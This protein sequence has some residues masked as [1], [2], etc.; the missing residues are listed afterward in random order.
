MATKNVDKSQYES[1]IFVSCQ[2]F[3]EKPS[4]ETQK[5]FKQKTEFI[6]LS[7][8]HIEPKIVNQNENLYYNEI[9]NESSSLEKDIYLELMKKVKQEGQKVVDLMEKL[10][11][12]EKEKSGLFNNLDSQNQ[13][14]EKLNIKLDELEIKLIEKNDIVLKRNLSKD[15]L[16]SELLTEKSQIKEIS[17]Q[18]NYLNE[19][20]KKRLNMYL[21]TSDKVKKLEGK[22]KIFED[23]N[24]MLKKELYDARD[25]LSE[26]EKL[27]CADGDMTKVINELNQ[28]Q[29]SLT[30]NRKKTKGLE[31]EILI[32]RK[33][34]EYLETKFSDE[35]IKVM[36]LKRIMVEK[37]KGISVFETL[38]KSY[39]LF[40][41][42]L[43]A[44]FVY[45]QTSRISN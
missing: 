1:N 16:V 5:K 23:E 27:N 21:E 6:N 18:K 33:T 42:L 13:T 38:T 31:E 25:T 40:G 2:K 43:T 39:V 9:M 29:S 45:F 17:T 19:Q 37:L 34:I 35:K 8:L 36:D 14:I 22:V 30:K 44:V 3:Y 41:Y 7:D 4:P 20:N 15:R 12:C 10:S 11:L 28:A 32:E 24:S 26:I